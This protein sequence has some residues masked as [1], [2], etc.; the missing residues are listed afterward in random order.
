MCTGA[1]LPYE[2]TVREAVAVAPPGTCASWGWRAW[3]A[4]MAAT[5]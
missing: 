5:V 1:L 3:R 4:I 2:Q